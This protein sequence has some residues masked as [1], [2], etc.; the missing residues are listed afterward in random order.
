MGKVMVTG[1]LR[2][3]SL[4]LILTGYWARSFT[5]LVILMD[6]YQYYWIAVMPWWVTYSVPRKP[7][8]VQRRT[9]HLSTVTLMLLK[10]V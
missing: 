5:H 4:T 7:N 9:F 8:R 3:V 1:A 6:Q 10:A 2:M